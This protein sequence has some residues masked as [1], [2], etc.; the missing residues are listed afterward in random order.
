V[1]LNTVLQAAAEQQANPWHDSFTIDAR[2]L[3]AELN[4]GRLGREN[5]ATQIRGIIHRL[6]A[7]R[8]MQVRL[9]WIDDNHEESLMDSSLW[10]I[11][12]IAKWALNQN[13]ATDEPYTYLIRVVPGGW[14]E[15]C[16]A[17]VNGHRDLLWLGYHDADCLLKQR[18]SLKDSLQ[19]SYL[20]MQQNRFTV[21]DWLCRALGRPKVNEKL[22]DRFKKKDLKKVFEA[23]IA[24]LQETI[25]PGF[26]LEHHSKDWTKTWVLKQVPRVRAVPISKLRQRL[27]LTQEEVGRMVGYTR[28]RI[29]QLERNQT[30]NLEAV[31]NIRR[32][33]L[34]IVNQNVNAAD[35]NN[36]Q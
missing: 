19:T 29:S 12:F 3:A 4:L 17:R 33:L 7:L 32:K 23:A 21:Y 1:R 30:S 24:D 18:T 35:V 10:N 13:S 2:D 5:K 27:G 14:V 11:D 28:G 36:R 31:E 8:R 26:E 9:Y 25:H 16:Q 15:Q 34:S 22:T 20:Q 6:A